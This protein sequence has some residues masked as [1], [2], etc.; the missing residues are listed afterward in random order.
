MT[1]EDL[2][3]AEFMDDDDDAEEDEVGSSFFYSL[4]A[5]LIHAG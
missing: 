1:V 5:I 2:L 4:S 3:G